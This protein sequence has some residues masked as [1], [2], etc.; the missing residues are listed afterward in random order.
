M[1]LPDRLPM[2][3]NVAT[4]LSEQHDVALEH[5]EMTKALLK[6]LGQWDARLPHPLFLEGA[7]WKQKQLDLY[8][9]TYPLTQPVGGAVPIMIPHG[10]TK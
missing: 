5:L 2:L 6:R 10:D 8:D 3:F 9:A 1:R 4:D 7:V